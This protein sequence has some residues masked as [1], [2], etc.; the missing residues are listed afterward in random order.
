MFP[1]L[2]YFLHKLIGTN[3][4]NI[5][6]I[7][8]TF[9]LLLVLAILS[10]AVIMVKELKRK[11]AQGLLKPVEETTVIGE[12]ASIMELIINSLIGFFLFFKI[13]YIIPNFAEFQLDPAALVFSSKG[14]WLAG[15]L[16]A[17]LFAGMKFQEKKKAQLDKPKVIKSLVYPH[18]RMADITM[19]AAISGVLGAKLFAIIEGIGEL[20]WETLVS[21]FLSGAGLAIYGGLLVGF[22]VVFLYLLRKKIQ[23]I[24]VMDA[25]APAFMVAY[26]V[27]RIGCQLSGDGDWGVAIDQM[28]WAQPTW[29]PDFLWGQTYPNNVADAGS[30]M[31]D[32]AWRYCREL[33]T[34]VFPTPIW[35]VVA[36]LAIA[37]FLWAIRKKVTIAGML[38]FIFLIFNGIERWFVEY[39]RINDTYDFMGGS[40]TQAQFI[41]AGLIL[42]GIVGIIVLW[43]RDKNQ[44]IAST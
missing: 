35:E 25:F 26:A 10:A 13:A 30:K 39:I 8:K 43:L 31:V 29:L 4:D 21:Q 7:V 14:N 36:S 6:S 27:G 22:L 3:P 11:E 9:G 33:D 23:P 5:F 40:Y 32:C 2:S 20:T 17:A 44:R 24:H 42:S 28:A 15:I 41:A 38:F 19:V 12:P 34:P 1:D 18:E 37:G 16:G